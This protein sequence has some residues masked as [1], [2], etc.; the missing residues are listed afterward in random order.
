MPKRSSKWTLLVRRSGRHFFC[1]CEQ[2]TNHA[3]IQTEQIVSINCLSITRGGGGSQNPDSYRTSFMDDPLLHFS[4]PFFGLQPKTHRCFWPTNRIW[5]RRVWRNHLQSRGRQPSSGSD[6]R[7][8]G[9]VLRLRT[10]VPSKVSTLKNCDYTIFDWL[11]RLCLTIITCRH[12]K[13][14]L[15]SLR[16]QSNSNHTNRGGEHDPGL[17]AA[18]ASFTTDG[19]RREKSSGWWKGLIQTAGQETHLHQ[20]SRCEVR[21][22]QSFEGLAA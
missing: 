16:A 17:G 15:I 14:E 2:R 1:Q 7:L 10:P 3:R 12:R 9:S 19:T 20:F 8:H 21:K 18:C 6:Q 22:Y 4:N 11:I 5:R 13:E